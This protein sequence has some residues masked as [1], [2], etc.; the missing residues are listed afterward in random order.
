MPKGNRGGYT[1]GTPLCLCPKCAMQGNSDRNASLVVGHA[2]LSAT[3]NLP[4]KSLMLFC[5]VRRGSR[6]TQVLESPRMPNVKAG[7]LLAMQ[8][9][10]IVP[11]GMAPPEGTPWMM[12]ALQ[13][14]SRQLRLFNE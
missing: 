13:A 7:H 12:S 6:K 10:E 1:P 5:D 9:V 3:Q 11:T 4:R 2:L 14:I 8:G